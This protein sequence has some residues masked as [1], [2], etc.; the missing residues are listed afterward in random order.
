[1][2]RTRVE[3]MRVLGILDFHERRDRDSCLTSQSWRPRGR[4]V[5]QGERRTRACDRNEEGEERNLVSEID[6]GSEARIISL[7][8]SRLSGHDILAEES[9]ARRLRDVSMDHRSPR[10]DHELLH[11]SRYLREHRVEHNG[12]I[13]AGVVYDPNLDELFPRSVEAARSSTAGASPCL[14]QAR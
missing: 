9:A 13:V 10:R 5:S 6:K 12:E 14:Q 3:P 8:K 11:A 4:P 1:M 2:Q 7:I